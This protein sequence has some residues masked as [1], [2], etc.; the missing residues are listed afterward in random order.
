M[1]PIADYIE[2][3]ALK[4]DPFALEPPLLWPGLES[5]AARVIHE[6]EFVRPVVW[7]HGP[8]GSG[9]STLAR[10]LQRQLQA[11]ADVLLFDVTQGVGPEQIAEQ[12]NELLLLPSG[13]GEL[14]APA[15]QVLHSDES[16]GPIVLVVDNIDHWPVS[17]LAQWLNSLQQAK[18]LAAS[19]LRLLLL[20]CHSPE[21]VPLDEAVSVQSLAMPSPDLEQTL[22][23]LNALMARAGAQAAV[24]TPEIVTAWWRESE[25][26]LARLIERARLFLLEN[27]QKLSRAA[28]AAEAGR[29]PLPTAHIITA[30]ALLAALAVVYLYSPEEDRPREPGCPSAGPPHPPR[31]QRRAP[32]RPR[33]H[34]RPHPAP[35]RQ[36]CPRRQSW[37]AWPGR[38]LCP[39]R[40]HH[41]R[42]TRRHHLRSLHRLRAGIRISARRRCP[43]R[44][45]SWK[46]SPGGRT[47]TPCRCWG[48]VRKRRPRRIWPGR[49]TAPC[50][51]FTRPCAK[52]SP[53]LWLW[54]GFTPAG[55]R[56]R[57]RKKT[58]PPG[59]KVPAPGSGRFRPCIK[60]WQGNGHKKAR[61][62]R[63]FFSGLFDYS[64]SS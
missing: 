40:R 64:S 28:P 60:N 63:A 7:V 32:Y 55:R 2:T 4:C 47:I 13:Q 25:G 12:L 16:A 34:R 57:R 50:C 23:W 56:L 24:F 49:A 39:A 46:Y 52:T 29:R 20:A 9:K 30:A 58:C 48:S 1:V 5:F 38:R 8:R 10:H 62:R 42:P 61:H 26:N 15:A 44:R 35:R 22:A 54:P 11:N 21:L 59:S 3:L 31:R 17:Q 6:L 45:M 18:L 51:A 36:K 53:G 37:R 14:F 27:S 43:T 33:R 19:K 41:P